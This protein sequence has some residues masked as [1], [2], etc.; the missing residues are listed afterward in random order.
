[1]NPFSRN[2]TYR[3]ANAIN[4]NGD[5][6]RVD[7]MVENGLFWRLVR[8]SKFEHFIGVTYLPR[9]GWAVMR[10]GGETNVASNWLRRE[11]EHSLTSWLFLNWGRDLSLAEVAMQ[12][13]EGFRKVYVSNTQEAT[14]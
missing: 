12:V 6:F 10:S 5:V 1:M 3:N 14:A 2:V 4:L 9:G 13:E 8:G 7:L 11:F